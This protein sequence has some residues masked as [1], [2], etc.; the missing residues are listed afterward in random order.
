MEGYEN[1]N[2]LTKYN[3]DTEDNIATLQQ[4]S[5]TKFPDEL[6]MFYKAIG[7]LYNM[8]V[9]DGISINIKNCEMLISDLVTKVN[10]STRTGTKLASLG[11]IDFIEYAW[12]G[13]RDEFKIESGFFNQNEI[14]FINENYKCVGWYKLNTINESAYY[15]Y[16]DREGKFTSILYDQDNF[17]DTKKEL[18]KMQKKSLATDNVEN[19]IKKAILKIEEVVSSNQEEE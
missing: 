18:V 2:T 5:N 1:Y 9:D 4:L 10:Y 6:V 19:I 13:N 14:D 16:F 17:D 15:I 11:L 7:G 3:K 8:Q 12:G